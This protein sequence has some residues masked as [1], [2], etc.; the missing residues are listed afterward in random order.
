ML[1]PL[2]RNQSIFKLAFKNCPRTKAKVWLNEVDKNND[3]LL[4][5]KQY[6]NNQLFYNLKILTIHQNSVKII[7]FQLT[8]LK[9]FC[10]SEMIFF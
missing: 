7:D 1:R 8:N 2:F 6:V 3:L 9:V 5:L 10:L 4:S